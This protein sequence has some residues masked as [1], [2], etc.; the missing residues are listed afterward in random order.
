MTRCDDPKKCGSRQPSTFGR[1]PAKSLSSLRRYD[2]KKRSCQTAFGFG[3]ILSKKSRQ[4][5]EIC[6]EKT[7]RPDGLRL[8]VNPFRKISPVTY[9]DDPKKSSSRKPS[10]FG[11]CLAKK[12]PAFGDVPRKNV[13]ARPPSAF[14]QSPA[15][16]PA[17]IRRCT[18]EKC[19]RPSASGCLF[20]PTA[21]LPKRST[22]MAR[23]SATPDN[24]RLLVDTPRKAPPAFGDVSP[25]NVH[26]RQLSTFELILYGKPLKRP[27]AITRKSAAPDCLRLLVDP[28][29]KI[30]SAFGDIPRKNVYARP[31][32]AAFPHRP[33]G[34]P[35]SS[36]RRFEKV[37]LQTAF[38]F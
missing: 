21:R 19:L 14:G 15:E 33:R 2:L 18:P 10:A 4:R 7:L 26:A 29:Q 13:H 34:S 8:L 20:P 11:R 27:A 30:P 24:L 22:A 12:T 32:P 37:Q 31:L 6:P 17:S 23:K 38:G 16:S 25:K 3:S 5:P 9:C 1:C 36:L 28:L 35:S